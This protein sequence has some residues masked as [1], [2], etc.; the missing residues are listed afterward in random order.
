MLARKDGR[1][2]F[3]SEL[4]NDGMLDAWLP[5]AMQP[6]SASYD[7]QE[8]AEYIK[9]KLR[10]KNHLPYHVEAAIADL[11]LTIDEIDNAL[12]NENEIEQLINE[13]NA[14]L[15]SAARD[16]EVEIITPEAE[17]TG[18]EVGKG[19]KK[20]LAKVA[21]QVTEQKFRELE[22]KAKVQEEPEAPTPTERPELKEKVAQ[23]QGVLKKILSKYGLK[24]VNVNLEEGMADEGSYSGQLIK[25]A[26]DLDN[27][28]RTLRHE[29]IHAL[30]ELGFFTPQQWKVLTDRA[31]SEW[32]EDRKSVV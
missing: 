20:S 22:R 8:S 10:Q 5:P 7:N 32:I 30:K 18:P 12:R 15:E 4:V 3:I 2:T 11:N 6:D 25:L 27:P 1:G 9:D 23:L 13:A 21:P 26:L 31:Q 19:P 28:V 24:D 17:A 29:A 14:E 16:R